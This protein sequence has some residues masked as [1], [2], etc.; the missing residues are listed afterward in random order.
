MSYIETSLEEKCDAL[1]LYI[2]RN[3]NK[4]NN[5]H[6]QINK[7]NSHVQK[8]FIGQEGFISDIF[9]RITESASAFSDATKALA[10]FLSPF[11]AILGRRTEKALRSY[12]ALNGVWT[13]R[14][15]NLEVDDNKFKNTTIKIVP[16]KVL[17]QRIE[18]AVDLYKI[19]EDTK[20]ICNST[21]NIDSDTAWNNSELF[22]IQKKLSVVGISIGK[23]SLVKKPDKD[24]H[25]QAVKGSIKHLGYDFHD[26]SSLMNDI[27]PLS[28]YISKKNVSKLTALIG[29]YFEYIAKQEQAII[30]L[31]T[32][33]DMEKEEKLQELNAK[34]IRLWSIS[35]ML[36]IM[37]VLCKSI[38]DD[39]LLLSRVAANSTTKPAEED[40]QY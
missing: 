36:K 18:V 14:L 13:N 23:F 32:L 2:E 11:I 20:Q 38:F 34:T 9:H 12:G 3:L 31:Q 27:K 21:V 39:V 4:V 24:Y 25:T 10:K 26:I 7:L 28:E 22:E 15:E 6:I 37:P 16:K 1:S 8:H 17:E 30:K 33:G 29:N 35:I 40:N 19:L 5:N